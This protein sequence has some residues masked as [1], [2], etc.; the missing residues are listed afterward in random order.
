MPPA[1]FAGGMQG[2]ISHAAAVAAM[3]VFGAIG[4]RMLAPSAECAGSMHCRA[5]LPACCGRVCPDLPCAA[6]CFVLSCAVQ[7]A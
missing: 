4:P 6:C 3:R 5:I 2:R 7:Q 1:V